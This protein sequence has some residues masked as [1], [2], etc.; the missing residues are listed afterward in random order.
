MTNSQLLTAKKYFY[1]KKYKKAL[2]IFIEQHDYYACGLC[3]L[4]LKNTELAKKYWELDKKNSP[5][6][7]WGLCI[8]DIINLNPQ[9]KPKFFQ[10]RAF[11]EIYLNLFL[12][13]NLIEWAENLISFN[14]L[15]FRINPESHKFIARALYANG[16][17][18]IAITFCKKSLGFFYGDPE[19]LLILAQ[20]YYLNKNMD[21]A[22]DTIQK[23]IA[24]SPDYYPAKL[25]KGV[26]D[27]LDEN[28]I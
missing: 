28:K 13:N 14:E 22:K 26:L 2:D 6:S 1:E 17:F 10:I 24:I 19:A 20:C 3:S 23:A 5:A 25:F 18:D 21:D 9:I 7:L 27:K 12:E 11:L 15:F 8:L 4:L 16:Y